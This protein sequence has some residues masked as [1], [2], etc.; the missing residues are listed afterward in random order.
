MPMPYLVKAASL[1]V[2]LL[3]SAKATDNT[4]QDTVTITQKWNYYNNP[5]DLSFCRVE[6]CVG[7]NTYTMDEM[8]AKNCESFKAMSENLDVQSQ[9]LAKQL[10][11]IERQIREN[12]RAKELMDIF[13]P[14]GFVPCPK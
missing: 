8:P 12:K 14:Q 4:Q 2:L 11:D 13:A 6:E 9:K 3:S 1:I 10:E 7:L 5:A